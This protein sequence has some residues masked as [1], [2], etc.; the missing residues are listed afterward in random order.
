MA[1]TWISLTATAW[2]A[3]AASAT[4][5]AK[6]FVCIAAWRWRPTAAGCWA[7][8]INASGPGPSRFAA[9]AARE[10]ALR[11]TEADLWAECLEAIGPVPEGA[12]WVS[13]ADRGSDAY[14]HL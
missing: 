5:G 14:S 9:K 8:P 7:W 3:W 6:A 11:R 1:L 12:T 4:T 13:V 10:Q 2:K